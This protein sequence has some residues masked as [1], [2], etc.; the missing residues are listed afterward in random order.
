MKKLQTHK[1]KGKIKDALVAQGLKTIDI[2]YKLNMHE[3]RNWKLISAKEKSTMH[4]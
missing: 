1:C 3:W 4:L 2:N